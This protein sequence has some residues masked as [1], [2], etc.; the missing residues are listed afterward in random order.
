MCWWL[1][2]AGKN[3]WWWICS[4]GNSYYGDALQYAKH[5]FSAM[6]L[7]MTKY[8]IVRECEN[9]LGGYLYVFDLAFSHL[10]EFMNE[11]PRRFLGISC[12]DLTSFALN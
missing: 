11:F 2:L 1:T 10:M 8:C 4:Y 3:M 12:R 7:Q 9:I 6:L 5:K